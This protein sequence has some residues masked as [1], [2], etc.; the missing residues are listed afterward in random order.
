MED[1]SLQ[2]AIDHFADKTS[3][4]GLLVD[5]AGSYSLSQDA[6][7]ATRG[8]ALTVAQAKA[9]TGSDNFNDNSNG[10][11]SLGDTYSNL[12]SLGAGDSLFINATGVNAVAESVDDAVAMHADA[13]NTGTVGGEIDSYS[14]SGTILSS[15]TEFSG[16]SVAQLD[17]VLGAVN[18]SSIQQ[19]SVEDS[20]S[21]IEADLPKT[22][23]S[24]PL[25]PLLS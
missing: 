14:F 15:S 23:L 21:A 1:A 13:S 10:S 5:S 20:V 9:A 17:A 4:L 11:Y 19:I 12:V 7:S 24:N 3:G 18:P 16:L 6:L 2:Q 22:P 25:S 8:A